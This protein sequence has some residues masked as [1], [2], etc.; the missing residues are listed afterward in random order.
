[1]DRGPRALTIVDAHRSRSLS[2]YIRALTALHVTLEGV[3]EQRGD[4][5]IFKPDLAGARVW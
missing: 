5:L 3:V 1:M 2:R 4:L